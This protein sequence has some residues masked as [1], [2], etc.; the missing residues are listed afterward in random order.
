[1][2]SLIELFSGQTTSR[3]FKGKN[4]SFKLRTLT[5]DEMTD[6]L[7]RTDLVALSDITK[8]VMIRKLTLAYALEA[9]NNVDIMAIPEISELRKSK[10]DQNISKADLL[11]EVLGKFDDSTIRT[12]YSCYEQLLDEH[13]KEALELK[14]D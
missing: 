1:M 6:V 3:V 5:T 10:Q 11:I 12:L 2:N 8:T 14:K 9:V 7:R 13:D 4:F